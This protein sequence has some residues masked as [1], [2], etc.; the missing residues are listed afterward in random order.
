MLLLRV[1]CTMT[2][3]LRASLLVWLD[4]LIVFWRAT[5]PTESCTTSFPCLHLCQ[6]SIGV[7]VDAC[8]HRPPRPGDGVQQS[9]AAIL[10]TCLYSA[11]GMSVRI[12]GEHLRGFLSQRPTYTLCPLCLEV[13]ANISVLSLSPLFLD[14][15]CRS[16]LTAQRNTEYIVALNIHHEVLRNVSL[17]ARA[18]TSL[19][20]HLGTPLVTMIDASY[21]IC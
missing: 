5:C 1:L 4:V 19:D 10:C 13:I 9:W 7:G 15:S 11:S 16:V 20:R 6:E 3:A 21:S 8:A 17:Q 14:R 2:S 18:K 12:N